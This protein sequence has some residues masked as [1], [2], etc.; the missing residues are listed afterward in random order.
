[1]IRHCPS[2]RRPA[3]LSRCGFTLIE[4][5]S[6]MVIIALLTAIIVS[7]MSVATRKS[8]ISRARADLEKLRIVIEEAKLNSGAYP[9]GL[10][11]APNVTN[12]P[13]GQGYHYAFPGATTPS[14]Y[15]L[16]SL[17]PNRTDEG[18]LGDDIS[19]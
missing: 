19:N 3:V 2:G 18:G 17:G 14:L 1:M 7:G 5:L 12:D 8:D 9:G 13:W 16:W 6:V 15:D 4:M 11:S 10:P